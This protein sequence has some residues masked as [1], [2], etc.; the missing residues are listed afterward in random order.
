MQ[1]AAV[2]LMRDTVGKVVSQVNFLPMQLY[3]YCIWLWLGHKLCQQETTAPGA[4]PGTN[5]DD[6]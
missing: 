6:N 4:I 5:T 3:L 2:K 1:F